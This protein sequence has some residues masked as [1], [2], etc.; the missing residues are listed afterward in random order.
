MYRRSSNLGTWP[1]LQVRKVPQRVHARRQ[2]RSR[3][4]VYRILHPLEPHNIGAFERG[5]AWACSMRLNIEAMAAAAQVLLGRHDFSTFRALGA[6]PVWLIL[7]RL[8]N[9]CIP[10]TAQADVWLRNTTHICARNADH[11]QPRG[12]DVQAAQLRRRSKHWTQYMSKRCR[13]C[14][15]GCLRT[16]LADTRSLKRPS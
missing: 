9:C 3:T 11:A 7:L 15:T 1:C 4:Y 10:S 6:R 16:R 12:S 8:S 13:V 5:H 2:A 14:P